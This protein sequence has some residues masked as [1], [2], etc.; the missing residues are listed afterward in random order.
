MLKDWPSGFFIINREIIPSFV[1]CY[2][3]RRL[4]DIEGV[5]IIF[6]GSTREIT[7]NMDFLFF[8]FLFWLILNI[9]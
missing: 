2:L 1:S 3:V 6:C 8:F 9:I 5:S 4:P 7:K